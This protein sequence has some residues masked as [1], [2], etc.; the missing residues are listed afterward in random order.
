MMKASISSSTSESEP[1]QRG[2]S[3]A[4]TAVVLF[5][6]YLLTHDFPILHRY[7][8]H[9]EPLL[10]S[11]QTQLCQR[12][13]LKGR[14][15]LAAEGINGTLSASSE[16]ALQAYIDEMNRFELLQRCGM[17]PTD[18]DGKEDDLARCAE[19]LFRGVDWKLSAATNT[20]T[21]TEPFP[22]LKIRVVKEIISTGGSVK[23][24]EIPKLGGT[25][26][27]P[28]QF[29]DAIIHDDNVVLIDV[30]NTFEYDIGHFVNPKTND[31]ALNPETVTFSSF[32]D[33]FCARRAEELK[34]K[35][36]LMYCTGGIR[37]EKASVMLKRK[38]VQDVSQ[39]QGG[40]HRYLE[41]YG[42]GGLFR[43]LNFVF[44]Q[45][46]DQ[47]HA[48]ASREIVGRCIEC[49]T[50]YDE[51]SGS[52]LCTVCRDLVLVCPDCCAR[53]REYHCKR[54]QAWKNCYFTFLDTFDQTELKA[55]NE[56]LGRLRDTY[57]TKNVRKTLF[58]QMEK[59]HNRIVQLDNGSE[60][61]DKS[62]P[63]RCRSCMETSDVCNGLC[64][65]FWKSRQGTS[66]G[67]DPILPIEIGDCV[68]PGPNWNTSRYGRTTTTNDMPRRG[69]VVEVKQWGM[70]GDENDCVLIEWDDDDCKTLQPYRWGAIGG[71]GS[72][73]YDV[74]KVD[75]SKLQI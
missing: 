24:D 56:E 54:H 38:G 60:M 29:H 59:V 43:G 22:D 14:V 50:P 30:R 32:E 66:K 46:V 74:Q 70:G 42:E 47:Q 23:V 5:Y 68:E 4:T 7:A 64:W 39:L 57:T 36:V 44:D 67:L 17:P 45:R 21:T 61:V 3:T 1:Q 6:K 49:S 75:S 34:K 31:V 2:G 52:R 26:L 65:G 20:T 40:I 62:A 48:T 63:R 12:L 15:L 8:K 13:A 16:E 33:T 37:C 10:Q 71:N 72:R 9:Y 19:Y 11:F 25:H 27:S 69:N 18:D 55:Q 58:R 28:S 41:E 73:H 51:I 53:S 35:K